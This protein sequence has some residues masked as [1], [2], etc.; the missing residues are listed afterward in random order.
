MMHL[1]HKK[2]GLFLKGYQGNSPLWTS[3]VEKAAVYSERDAERLAKRLLCQSQQ[4]EAVGLKNDK[5]S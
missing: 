4:V 5:Q 3:D 1:K 2:T